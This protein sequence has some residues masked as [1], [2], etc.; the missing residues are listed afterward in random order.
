MQIG[1]NTATH[2]NNIQTIVMSTTAAIILLIANDEKTLLRILP[3]K[4]VARPKKNGSGMT[5]A[6]PNPWDVPGGKLKKGETAEQGMRRELL[7]ETGLTLHTATKVGETHIPR[8]NPCR[9]LPVEA[10]A[11][12]VAKGGDNKRHR[13][14]TIDSARIT[15]PRHHGAQGPLVALPLH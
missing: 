12:Q 10:L 9:R 11:S 13:A 6:D 14:H 15:L 3:T 7:E 4:R 2:N 8:I 1:I 5:K